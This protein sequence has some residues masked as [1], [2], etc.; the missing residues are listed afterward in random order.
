[1]A[2]LRTLS[3]EQIV[4]S[5]L[6]QFWRGGF[7]ETSIGDL[8]ATTGASRAA[9]YGGFGGKD[10]LFAATL[11]A[12]RDHVVTPAFTQVEAPG[13]GL[14]DIAAY[15]ETQIALAETTGLPGP[16]CLMANSMTELAGRDH[17][18]LAA[19]RAHNARLRAGFANALRAESG[20][21]AEDTDALAATCAIFA[22]GLWSQSRAVTDAAPLRAAVAAFLDL[23]RRSHK[24]V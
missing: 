19:V 21:S 20:T 5:A 6:T 9:I 10:G 11:V 13:A 18:A 24:D 14:A 2:R 15:F 4:A 16:G 7:H 12:Y 3:E 22:Q 1:M 17:P 23:V 8:V